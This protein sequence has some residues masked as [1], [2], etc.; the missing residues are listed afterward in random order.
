MSNLPQAVADR[1]TALDLWLE[2]RGWSYQWLA[3]V[4]G[5][6]RPL[7]SIMFCADTIPSKRHKQL[8]SLGIPSTLIPPVYNG[9][10]GRPGRKRIL[11]SPPEGYGESSA[12]SPS[13][14][15]EA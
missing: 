9:P 4:M 6:S 15:P 3:D 11:P 8:I 5:V 13:G 7:V 2:E 12:G 10:M 1:K 14:L